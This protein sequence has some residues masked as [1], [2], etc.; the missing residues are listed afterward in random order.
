MNTPDDNND[1]VNLSNNSDLKSF[2]E[3]DA[4]NKSIP[5]QSLEQFY[6]GPKFNTDLKI[7]CNSKCY[8]VHSAILCNYSKYF[9]TLLEN[10]KL[11]YE[12]I[13]DIKRFA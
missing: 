7:I 11:P 1:S 2:D 12:P 5:A 9:Y 4:H 6:Y 10:Q 13:A 8:N 3:L